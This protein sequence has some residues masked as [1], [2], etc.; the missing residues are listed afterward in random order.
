MAQLRVPGKKHQRWSGKQIKLLVGRIQSF[1]TGKEELTAKCA[2]PIRKVSLSATPLR[3]FAF[4]LLGFIPDFNLLYVLRRRRSSRDGASVSRLLCR[5]AHARASRAI[6]I[7]I[8]TLR[9]LWNPQRIGQ[10]NRL[11]VLKLIFR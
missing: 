6:Q 5:F 7:G 2:K 8:G 4:P 10:R 3:A 11:E 1:R 9:S